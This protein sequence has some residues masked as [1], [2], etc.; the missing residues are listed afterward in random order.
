M[1]M[2]DNNFYNLLNEFLRAIPQTGKEIIS[3]EF[4]IEMQPGL[5]SFG[6][7]FIS[8]D[9][10]STPVDLRRIGKPKC[11]DLTNRIEEFHRTTTENGKNK[12]NKAFIKL[13][14][15]GHAKTEFIWDEELEQ[16]NINAYDG[17]PELVRQKWYWEEK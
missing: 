2:T 11:S 1:T 9:N 12:W 16:K 14:K 7:D 3:T 13:S 17:D 5:V 8:T 10:E 4:R 15:D 6:G